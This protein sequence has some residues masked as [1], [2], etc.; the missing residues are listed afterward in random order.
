MW[1]DKFGGIGRYVK[2]I[3]LNMLG[4]NDWKFILLV[5]SE[6]IK[7]EISQ[8]FPTCSFRLLSASIF[9]LKEQ[10]LLWKVFRN[11]IYFGHPI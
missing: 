8:M 3:V 10:F 7:D 4:K 9:S 5:S 2:E 6:E 1:G 11:V